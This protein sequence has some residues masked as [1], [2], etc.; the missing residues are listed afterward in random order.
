MDRQHRAWTLS[1]RRS[2][3]QDECA[4]QRDHH[5][6]LFKPEVRPN[7]ILCTTFGLWPGHLCISMW[8]RIIDSNRSQASNASLFIFVPLLILLVLAIEENI[9]NRLANIGVCRVHRQQQHGINM[10]IRGYSLWG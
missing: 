6:A 5:Q 9:P 3:S 2:T 1:N 7:L 10:L 8:K 4:N